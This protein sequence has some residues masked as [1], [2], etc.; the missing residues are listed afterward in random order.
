M[1][2]CPSPPEPAS[3]PLDFAA[4]IAD[5][6]RRACVAH[7]DSPH[8]RM[9]YR[10]LGEG[11]TLVVVQGLASTYRGYAP[12]LNRLSERFRTVI[13]DYP[14]ENPDDGADL[15]WITHNDLTDDLLGLLDH[16][17]APRALA[18]AASFGSTVL[19]SAVNRDPERV[20]RAVLQGG[21]VH[22]PLSRPERMAL[23]AGRRLPGRMAGLPLRG[24]VLAWHNRHTFPPE[25]VAD[26]WPIF[27][28]ENGAT[29]IAGMAHRLDMLA[30]VDLRPLL[31][32]ITT[33]TLVIHGDIDGIVP[34]SHFEILRTTLPR[35]EAALWPGIGHQPHFTHPER[36][37]EAIE[38]FL[39]ASAP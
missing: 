6:E 25:V 37:A 15:P 27:V 35:A 12:I 22:R 18:F 30:E 17:G 39:A 20:A 1:S 8:Y 28:A 34:R 19:L 32:G 7:W 16:L 3:P 26:R 2:I 38:A 13:H 31:A 14:G 33:P 24:P 23:R 4:E 29:Q 10:V 11:P 21:F 5:Y 36:L 9:T